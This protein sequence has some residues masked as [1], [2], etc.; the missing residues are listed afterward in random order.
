MEGIDMEDVRDVIVVG[1]GPVGFLTALGLARRGIRVTLLEAESGINSAPRAAI[2]FPTTLEII[3]KLGLLEDAEA[4]G[5]PSTKFSMRFLDDGEVIYSDLAKTMPPGTKYDHNLHMGQHIL[6]GLVSEHLQ[7]LPNATIR[8]D[9]R[10]VSLTQ[11][12]DGVTLAVATPD[13]PREI[14]ADWVV[15]TDGARS[16]VRQLLDLPFEGHTWPD[17]FVATNVEYDF[18]RYGFER[19][20]MI[21]DP[22]NWAVVARLGRENLWRVT[23]GEDAS[24]VEDDIYA[25]IP[26]HYAAVFPG[27][28]PYRIVAWSP[29][30]VQERA[31]P[32][33][34]VGRVLLAGDAAHACNPCG[35]MGLT[36]GVI[37]A[38]ALIAVL[39]AVIEGR[40]KEDVL[41]F[42]STERHRVFREVTSPVATN[43]KRQM[44]EK[45]PV[46]RK[47]DRDAFRANVENP[48]N[49][50]AATSLSKLIFGNPMPV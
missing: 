18:E 10:V 23:F 31:A 9:H 30:R 4:I 16:S 25:R 35:G 45:D 1:A 37:D 5:L 22:D 48:D 11:D 6:A 20:N 2:Y 21:C 43:F 40:A 39:A 33:F 36:T 27:K 50:P 26:N 17:R 41:D 32:R 13:G 15:G 34:R 44:S 8:W 3:D 42:Y 49:S 29:Y 38:D 14:K 7:R 46:R 12:S 24:L 47:Q 19:A 28:E